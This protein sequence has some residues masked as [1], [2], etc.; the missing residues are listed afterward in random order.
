MSVISFVALGLTLLFIVIA[1]AV[2]TSVIQAKNYADTQLSNIDIQ[3][4]RRLDTIPNLLKTARKF[5]THEQDL[6]KEVTE[7]RSQAAGTPADAAPEKAFDI[8]N[9][10]AS[11]MGSLMVSV[12]NYP[13]L[14][15]D[16]VV[17]KAMS[18]LS[19]IEEDI[20]AS[21][22]LYNNAVLDFNNKFDIFPYSIVASML[23]Y[24][25][26]VPYQDADPQK[27]AQSINVDD[28]L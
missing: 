21:R 1:Y 27:I 14:K 9:K 19:L 28:H 11:K 25:R 4:R 15:S 24:E 16:S 2:Y 23:N 20:S 3:L 18:D 5:M 26:M 10:L 17:Q 7:L 22:R 6:I 8:N 13:D 12:E